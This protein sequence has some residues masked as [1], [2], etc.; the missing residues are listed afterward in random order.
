VEEYRYGTTSGD[1]KVNPILP[2]DS[3]VWMPTTDATPY[4]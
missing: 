1:L 4:E 3:S 2:H